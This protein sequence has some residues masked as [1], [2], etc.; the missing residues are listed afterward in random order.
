MPLPFKDAFCR[1]FQCS[2]KDYS[3]EAVWR[4]LYPHAR[5]VWRALELAGGSAAHTATVLMEMVGETRSKEDLLDVI[6]EYRDE[7]KPHS[8][9]LARRFKIRV[10]IL[11]L[12]ALHDEIRKAEAA[13]PA[14]VPSAPPPTD[15]PA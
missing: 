5:S 11:R 3:R 2:A 13:M 1:H 4:C 9:L 14:P 12:V 10:S 6:S 15:P 7:I 8:G